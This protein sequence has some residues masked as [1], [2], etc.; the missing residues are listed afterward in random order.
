MYLCGVTKSNSYH[1]TTKQCNV[2]FLLITNT[3]Y[4]QHSNQSQGQVDY[5]LGTSLLT[6]TF[7]GRKKENSMRMNGTLPIYSICHVS[8]LDTLGTRKISLKLSTVYV[9]KSPVL[10][11]QQAP[12]NSE[13]APSVQFFLD[14]TMISSQKLG[15]HKLKLLF[16]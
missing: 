8:Q 6:L 7:K 10:G 2:T 3:K 14:S 5:Y 16:I 9:V 11:F 4:V 15:V 1:K 12:E 13:S